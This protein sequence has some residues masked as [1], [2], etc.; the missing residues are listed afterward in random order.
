[1]IEFQFYLDTRK[2]HFINWLEQIGRECGPVSTPDGE[3]GSLTLDTQRLARIGLHNSPTE[4]YFPIIERNRDRSDNGQSEQKDAPKGISFDLLA[5]R[6]VCVLTRAK[7]YDL[8]FGK[9]YSDVLARVA[10]EWDR[11]DIIKGIW[12]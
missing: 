3:N 4:V 11:G 6:A 1:M 10:E 5:I 7:C 9:F 2:D 8:R 12:A